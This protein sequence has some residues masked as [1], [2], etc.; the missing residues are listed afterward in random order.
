MYVIQQ[1]QRSTLQFTDVY[2]VKEDIG[3]GSYSI[4]KR[5]VHKSTGMFY[6]VNGK[7]TSTSVLFT[8]LF[9]VLIV[10]LLLAVLIAY[11]L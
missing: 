8:D 11:Q 3:V 5:C 6:A 10:E 9:M 1:P 2:D 7:Y 4:C